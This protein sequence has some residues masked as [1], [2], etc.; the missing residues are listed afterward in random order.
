MAIHYTDNA[1]A[2]KAIVILNPTNSNITYDLTGN[3]KMIAN[4]SQAGSSEIASATGTVTVNPIELQVYVN[5]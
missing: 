3:W 1:S 2:R 5:H 4:G